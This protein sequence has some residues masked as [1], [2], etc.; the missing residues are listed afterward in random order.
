VKH[1]V[2]GVAAS[3]ACL[4]GCDR[5]REASG[6]LRA[7]DHAACHIQLYPTT[8]PTSHAAI[9]N[10]VHAPTGFA[11][12]YAAD[13]HQKIDVYVPVGP[14]Q[15]CSR[16]HVPGLVVEQSTKIPLDEAGQAFFSCVPSTA[17][18]VDARAYGRP[19]TYFLFNTAPNPLSNTEA[20][21]RAKLSHDA[22]RAIREAGEPVARSEDGGGSVCFETFGDDPFDPAVDL[23]NLGVQIP[24]SFHE[25]RT[26][27]WNCEIEIKAESKASIARQLGSIPKP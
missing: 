1:W 26:S 12:P 17:E 14:S 18:R 25:R 11:C 6:E 16:I 5:I 3:V 8:D 19:Q 13:G 20:W 2:I 10:V 4:S 27:G 9:R 23:P 15:S 7:Q 21:A 22:A 24:A